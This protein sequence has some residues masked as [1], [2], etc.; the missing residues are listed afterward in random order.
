MKTIEQLWKEN[1]E[2]AGLK[3]VSDI[4][5]TSHLTILGRSPSGDFLGYWSL[6]G[7]GVCMDGPD[8]CWSLYQ[9]RKPR[10]RAYIDKEYDGT[11]VIACGEYPVAAFPPS[12]GYCYC[13]RKK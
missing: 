2:R 6:S 13:G 12:L 1:G 10:W 8:D 9:E 4:D 11:C 5:Q 7:R 3:V